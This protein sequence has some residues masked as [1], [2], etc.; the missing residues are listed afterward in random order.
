MAE[1][2]FDFHQDSA[3]TPARLEAISALERIGI[4]VGLDVRRYRNS[5]KI[6]FRDTECPLPKS[7]FPFNNSVTAN[8]VRRP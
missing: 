7:L 2:Y 4:R 1:C 3:K 5:I 8:V 6:M